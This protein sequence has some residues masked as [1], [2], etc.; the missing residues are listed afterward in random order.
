MFKSRMNR[1]ETVPAA[2][3]TE[4]DKTY[5]VVIDEYG[6]KDLVETGETNRF[7]AIQQYASQCDIKNIIERAM[8]G[9]TSGLYAKQ[10]QYLDV[11]DMPKNL[12]EAQQAML[13]IK[14]E[15]YGLTTDIRNKFNNSVDEYIASFGSEEWLKKINPIKEAELSGVTPKEEVS[16]NE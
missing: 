11:T 3:G 4:Y 6:H 13:K 9:D 16:E 12:A 2:T 15:F 8:A 10:G 7:E 14:N 1:P 5:E